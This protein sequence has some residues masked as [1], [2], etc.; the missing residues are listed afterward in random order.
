MQSRGRLLF[1]DLTKDDELARLI[2]FL[3]TK[4]MRWVLADALTS[5][6]ILSVGRGSVVDIE[7]IYNISFKSSQNLVLHAPGDRRH[8]GGR[9]IRSSFLRISECGRKRQQHVMRRLKHV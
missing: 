8:W 9:F 6:S 4:K 3:C 1:G 2:V 5:C 7:G